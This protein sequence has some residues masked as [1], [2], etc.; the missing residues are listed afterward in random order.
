MSTTESLEL[1]GVPLV[2]RPPADP[3]LPAPLILLWHGF[4]KPNSEELLAETFPLEAVQ[5]WKAYLGLPLF[6][7]R[8]L[9]GGVEEIMRLQLEDYVLQLLLPV[10][11]QAM[12]E[13]PNVVQALQYRAF[14]N[15]NL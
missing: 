4:G 7:K 15:K 1:A 6:G 14:I 9:S 12:G 10:I 13:L 11:E 5:A 8:L 3:S 2:L